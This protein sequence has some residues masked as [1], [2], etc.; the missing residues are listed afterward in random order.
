MLGSVLAQLVRCEFGPLDQQKLFERRLPSQIIEGRISVGLYV[1]Y[2]MF[3]SG[4]AREKRRVSFFK[5]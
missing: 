2:S 4:L 3:A 1:T 5:I